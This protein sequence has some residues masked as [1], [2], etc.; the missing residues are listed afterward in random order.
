MTTQTDEQSLLIEVEALDA[1]IEEL[2]RQKREALA[3]IRRASRRFE[4][5]DE[6]RRKLSPKTFAGDSGACLE[7]EAVEDEHETLNR[8]VRVAN[9]AV[10]EF[11]R[12]LEETKAKRREAQKDVHRQRHQTLAGELEET[13]VERDE[14]ADRLQET[15]D[16]HAK[17][18]SQMLQEL[19]QWDPETANRSASESLTENEIWAEKRFGRWWR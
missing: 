10:P 17:I 14:L 6:Q 13:R 7:L 1:E 9:S 12:M 11:D 3:V 8:S 5:L 15:L 4:E 2:E 18:K 19:Y 16:R